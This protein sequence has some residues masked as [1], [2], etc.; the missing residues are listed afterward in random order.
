MIKHSHLSFSTAAP[1]V[2][3]RLA[4]PIH[5]QGTLDT[6]THKSWAKSFFQPQ[7]YNTSVQPTCT[8]P[9]KNSKFYYFSCEFLPSIKGLPFL[10]GL[11]GGFCNFVG[12]FEI[13][14]ETQ[15]WKDDGED[16]FF[17]WVFCFG[18]L[19]DGCGFARGF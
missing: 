4:S 19:R 18:E 5:P 2:Q 16:C 12:K 17:A 3:A 10:L 7:I 9:K 8:P 15:I 6:L 1:C 14:I 11:V 13:L